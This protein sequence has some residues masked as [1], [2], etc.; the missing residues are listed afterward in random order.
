MK[1]TYQ[2]FI[3]EKADEILE[4]LKE[5]ISPSEH[6]KN[7]ICDMLTEK[8][9]KG[10]LSADDDVYDAFD[11]SDLISLLQMAKLYETLDSLIEKGLIGTLDDDENPEASY[12]LTEKGKLYMKGLK[13]K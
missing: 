3:I 7:R 10:E 8:F 5:E 4:A 2:P 9:I 13:K 6:I 11:D 12:F 1:K